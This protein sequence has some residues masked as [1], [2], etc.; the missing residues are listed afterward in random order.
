MPE[1]QIKIW[2]ENDDFIKNILNDKN[3]NIIKQCLNKSNFY[4]YEYLRL[5]ILYEFG[6]IFAEADM[7]ILEHFNIQ[8]NDEFFY[9]LT[10]LSDVEKN[11]GLTLTPIIIN[12]KREVFIKRK[13]RGAT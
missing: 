5:K 1:H 7:I 8:D 13:L 12:K 3:N 10:Y 2:T 6:G 4:V 9:N 11:L